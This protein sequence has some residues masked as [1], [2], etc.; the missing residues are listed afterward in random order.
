MTTIEMIMSLAIDLV[1]LTSPLERSA[2]MLRC[3]EL[4]RSRKFHRIS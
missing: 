2:V 1:A 4:E 3:E